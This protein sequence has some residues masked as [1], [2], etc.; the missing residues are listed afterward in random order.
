MNQPDRINILADGA[1]TY[2][3]ML[4][5]IASARSYILFANYCFREG[6][7]MHTFSR[8]LQGAARRGVA[9]YILADRHGSSD[10]APET[11]HELKQAGAHWVWFRP[12]SKKSPWSY[13]RRLHKKIL[14]IDSKLG[15]LGGIGVADFWLRPNSGYP[16]PWRDI[17][18]RLTGP[19]VT[20]L[21]VSF[22]QSWR[23]FSQ[24]KLAPRS[25]PQL[26]TGTKIKPITSEP[27]GQGM[28]AIGKT[29]LRL[30]SHS[31]HSIRI[32]SAYFGPDQAMR[33]ILINAARKGIKVQLLVNGPYTTHPV[34]LAAGRHHYHDLLSAGVEIYEYQPT[35]LHTKMILIDKGVASIGSANLN[36]RSA[37]HDEEFNLILRDSELI[38]AL[39]RRFNEDLKQ[40]QPVKFEQWINRTKK[41]Q[42]KH[43][44]SSVGRYFF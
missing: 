9:V 1:E 33:R 23:K 13:N 29:H 31:K 41:E 22:E 7:V 4:Q 16:S 38:S 3:H 28:T 32:A 6:R 42:L 35:K 15:F 37:Y 30:M 44:I 12:F 34:A 5:A 27:T 18:F 17:H 25:R 24:T 2:D 14:V 8:A 11:V 40:S 43:H 26:P 39:H 36:F 20:S 21:A 10:I 19:V